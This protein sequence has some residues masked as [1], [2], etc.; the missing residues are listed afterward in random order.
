LACRSVVD[1][2]SSVVSSEA[3]DIALSHPKPLR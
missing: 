2:S 3:E 1:Q